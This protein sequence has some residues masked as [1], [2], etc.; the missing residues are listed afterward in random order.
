MKFEYD[1]C[2]LT[3]ISIVCLTILFS[4]L[5]VTYHSEN[6]KMIENGYQQET[7]AGYSSPVWRKP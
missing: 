1:W 5:R 2:R 6:M 4:I 3:A 7:I